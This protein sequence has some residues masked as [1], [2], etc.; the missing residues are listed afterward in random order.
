MPAQDHRLPRHTLIA[1]SGVQ[2]AKI[3][4]HR[5]RHHKA[6]PHEADQPFDFTFVVTLAGT[7]KLVLEQI[8]A[9]QGAEH[10]AACPRPVA[11]YPRHRQSGVIVQDRARHAAKE[12]KRFDVP[13][14][15]R[16]GNFGR[17]GLEERRVAVRQIHAEIMVP[18][19]L[20]I[21]DRIRLAKIDLSMAGP[22]AQRH[23]HLAR[24]PLLQRHI[25]AH[26]GLAA[27]KSALIAQ[28]FKNTDHGVVLLGVNGA[29]VVQDLVDE[30]RQTFQLAAERPAN[31]PVWRWRRKHQ[32]LVDRLAINPEI[33]SST[34][35]AHLLHQHSVTDLLI[36]FHSLHPPPPH[37]SEGLS[38]LAPF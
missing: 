15:K 33:P 17:I 2:R 13:I 14:T 21:D 19:Q 7:P 34:T 30:I 35:A 12:R 29:I 23:E 8:M 26:D 27:R 1:E 4:C 36:K 28:P 20:A 10:L 32:H 24:A 11:Q 3:R 37:K 31:A 6:P 5:H 25:L 16:L 18:H 38:G 9:L 22:M